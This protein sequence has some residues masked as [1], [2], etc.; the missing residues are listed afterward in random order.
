MRERLLTIYPT[1]FKV[2]DQ[3]KRRSVGGC[4]LGARL[5][6]MPELTD[7]LW[8]ERLDPR[9]ALSANGE[10]LALV[11]ALSPRG[12]APGDKGLSEGLGERTL[13]LIRQLKSAGLSVDD[14]AS[15][16]AMQGPTLRARLSGFTEVFRAY[17][18]L[19]KRRELADRHDR[20][21]AA[22]DLLLRHEAQRTRPRLLDGVDKLL[23]AELYDLSLLEFMVISAL[24]RII[25][26]AE[27]VIQAEHY[28]IDVARF[29]DL[30][31][32][33]FVAEESI[34]DQILPSFV[35]R[36]GR[37]GNLGFL[38]EHL[39]R[40]GQP[41]APEPDRSVTLIEARTPRA[42]AEAAARTVRELLEREGKTLSPGRIAVLSADLSRYRDYLQTAFAD[43]RLP[44]R[45]T[46]GPRLS[47]A[48]CARALI[49]L[50]R[51]P[52][53]AFSRQALS[54]V[55]DG[56]F[57]RAAA[58]AFPGLPA[59]IGYIDE[60]TVPF[61][62]CV[63]RY[64]SE[65]ERNLDAAGDGEREPRARRLDGFKRAAAAWTDFLG[66]LAPLAAPATLLDYLDRVNQALE[67]IR[68]D[69][70]PAG[71]VDGSAYAGASLRRTLTE[72]H[73]E[74]ARLG[75]VTM[76][77]P[78]EWIR[79]LEQVF[80][81]GEITPAG[82]G[83]VAM[84][85]MDAR[86]LD[87][88][89]VVVLGLNEGV[90]PRYYA[91]DPLVPEEGLAELN[92]ALRAALRKRTDLKAPSAPG[93]ILRS[94][95]QRVS[96]EPFL[97]FLA[98]SM[99]TRGV[100][101][102]YSR[103]DEVGGPLA[104]SPYIEE[105]QRLLG[106]SATMSRAGEVEDAFTMRQLLNRST[107]HPEIDG[108]L[109]SCG[110]PDNRLESIR[111]RVAIERHRE[112]YLARPTREEVFQAAR[113]AAKKDERWPT[114]DT[115][116]PDAEKF[117]SAGIYDGH[118]GPDAALERILLGA[119]PGALRPWSATQLNDLAACGFRYFA[120]RIL[121][122][123]QP[124]EADHESTSLE[125]GDLIHRLLKEFFDSNPDFSNPAQALRQAAELA[126]RY[127]PQLAAA[128]RDPAFF[129]VAW[130]SLTEILREVVRWETARRAEGNQPSRLHS[131]FTFEIP[132]TVT[133]KNRRQLQIALRGSI[134]RLE[135]FH[136]PAGRV[137]R[138]RVLDYKSSRNRNQFNDR[139]RISSFATFDLQ[140]AVYLLAAVASFR[141]A[142]AVDARA[143]AAYVALRNRDKES[144]GL[145]VDLDLLDANCGVAPAPPT[146]L[147]VA[148]RIADLLEQALAGRFDVD[149][150]RCDSFCPYRAVCRFSER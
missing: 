38:L 40:D 12:G 10:Y 13:S 117:R 5:T 95:A 8:Q 3:L 132:L 51:L 60:T 47:D 67:L 113:R 45:L 137:E 100:F 106:V 91:Y 49:D 135:L 84:S 17:E 25:G 144:R 83:V 129:E 108:V 128:A 145:T 27:V 63:E 15:A 147:P 61:R 118:V 30:T 46:D 6:T 139:L 120:A 52:T 14:W 33:R 75:A 23:V 114:R 125:S 73:D 36:G 107:T 31:W 59:E 18:A 141:E 80:S 94:R 2:A 134:D 57:I 126:A 58:A 16:L 37:P 22:L 64:R 90:F 26:D 28:P 77:S 56:V 42:E 68:F 127:Q 101:L 41:A 103:E 70:L 111:R 9:T 74:A 112:G 7:A 97:F 89:Y 105:V 138:L 96:R 43:F 32:N 104:P 133:L 121:R 102:A 109:R 72:L 115:L 4:L 50:L 88:D 130:S 93:P 48:P 92:R 71:V 1:A 66:A 29:A 148:A 24:I 98:L 99:A 53:R 124:E 116:A 55:C 123:A 20:E 79:L 35:R 54:T 146:A 34:A 39:F 149:P 85:V 65:L 122:L 19:L 81:A 136:D 143:E 11:E 140:M 82:N 76:R 119:L 131:E 87:F 150:L 62:A 142:L 21:R 78:R 44:L 110:V 69:F 86:S